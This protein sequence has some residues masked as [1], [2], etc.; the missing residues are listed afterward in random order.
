MSLHSGKRIHSYKWDVLPIEKFV[1]ER[2]EELAKDKE[3]PEIH[4]GYPIFEW[5]PGDP[6]IDVFDKNTNL[7]YPIVNI[8]N[9][10]YAIEED[11]TVFEE[12]S[13]ESLENEENKNQNVEEEILEVIEEENIVSEDEENIVSEDQEF[14]SETEEGVDPHINENEFCEEPMQDFE[15]RVDIIMDDINDSRYETD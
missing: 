4:N 14:K 15:N 12:V 9:E 7:D 11:E 2:V 3:Q 10:S 13:Q 8:L 6:V 5:A 1:I